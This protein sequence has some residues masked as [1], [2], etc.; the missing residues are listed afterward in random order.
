MAALG[1]RCRGR[2]RRRPAPGGARAGAGSAGDGP[3][4]ADV[5]DERPDG[6]PRHPV[7]GG[8]EGEPPRVPLGDVGHAAE[9]HEDAAGDEGP[10]SRGARRQSA[11]RRPGGKDTNRGHTTQSLASEHRQRGDPAGHVQALG[12]PVEA[13]RAGRDRQPRR[14][15]AGGCGRTARSRSRP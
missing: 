4:G 3:L 10:G 14:V 12:E 13:G 6:D 8:G 5:G 9:H 11:M 7:V 2:G 15:G 1:G